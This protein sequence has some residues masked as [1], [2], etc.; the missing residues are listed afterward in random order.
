MI[1]HLGLLA[2]WRLRSLSSTRS[3]WRIWRINSITNRLCTIRTLR[4][5]SKSKT[6]WHG[7]WVTCTHKWITHQHL[8]ELVFLEG[9]Y[10]VNY[11]TD[12]KVKKIK[13]KEC[14]VI[15]WP[16]RFVCAWLRAILLLVSMAGIGFSVRVS[17]G[18]NQVLSGILLL[19]EIEVNKEKGS[20][21]Q[22]YIK[23]YIVL[24]LGLSVRLNWHQH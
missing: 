12:Y 9:N 4:R 20:L 16:L 15:S 7:N 11:L 8:L 13:L 6:P 3:T 17:D 18:K 5:L 22:R 19:T 10:V 23:H 2:C 24:F 1:E 14:A 21:R